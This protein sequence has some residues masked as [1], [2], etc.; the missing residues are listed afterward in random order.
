LGINWRPHLETRWN[1]FQQGERA[2]QYGL[3][4]LFSLALWQR[5]V[6]AGWRECIGTA[7]LRQSA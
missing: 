4:G 5:H 3:W 1:Q 7:R 2:H 6:L